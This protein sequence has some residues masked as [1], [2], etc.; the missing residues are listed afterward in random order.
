MCGVVLLPPAAKLFLGVGLSVLL[1]VAWLEGGQY[2]PERRE[3]EVS[4]VSSIVPSNTAFFKL[5]MGMDKPSA[6]RPSSYVVDI[7]D[8]WS[9]TS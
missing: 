6:C 8:G 7:G 3:A 2:A 1:G 4:T 9:E 5:W